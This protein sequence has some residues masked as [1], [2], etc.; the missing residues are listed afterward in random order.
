MREQ[1]ERGNTKGGN[2][3]RR[4]RTGF[5]RAERRAIGGEEGR[6]G[7]GWGD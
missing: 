7:E 1:A 4:G 5:T 2:E 6:E 3:Q